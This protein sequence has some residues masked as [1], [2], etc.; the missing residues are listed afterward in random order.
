MFEVV[1]S[2]PV[3]SC[4]PGNR[5]PRTVARAAAAYTALPTT[6]TASTTAA[7]NCQYAQRRLGFVTAGRLGT[8]V[9]TIFVDCAA[10]E[11]TAFAVAGGR[12]DTRSASANAPT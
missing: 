12:R 11:S 7:D 3:P 9:T 4:P 8:L 10:G 5:C 2:G 6:T 1:R